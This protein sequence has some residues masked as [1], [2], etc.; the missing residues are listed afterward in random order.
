MAEEKK[1]STLPSGFR[2]KIE[3]EKGE[4]APPTPFFKEEELPERPAKEE[5]AAQPLEAELQNKLTLLALVV[6]FA[7]LVL[8]YLAFS[9]MGA[10]KAEARAIAQELRALRDAPATFTSQA[11]GEAVV[12]FD[13]PLNQALRESFEIPL[14]A[15]LP[16][17][18]TGKANLPF[19]G[20]VDVK[21][22]GSAHIEQPLRADLTR[23]PPTYKLTVRE[24]APLTAT[25]TTTVKPGEAWPQLDRI[26]QRLE[27][28]GS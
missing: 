12:S 22:N 18:G 11:R 27:A 25:L 8:A 5:R 19:Y 1:I 14:R 4:K 13:V 9:G 3:K 15:E 6:A 2:K 20:V 17:E 24:T 26:I 21:F 10:L 7:A 28:V 23:V 16:I